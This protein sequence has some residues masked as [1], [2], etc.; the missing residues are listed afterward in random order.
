LLVLTLILVIFLSPSNS[1]AIS[2]SSLDYLEDNSEFN[3][4]ALAYNDP[5]NVT[6]LQLFFD[7]IFENQLADYNIPGV[8]L[9]VVNATDILYL[10]GYGYANIE[11]SRLV[12]PNTTMFRAASISK[13]FVWTAV[14]QLVEQEIL[15]LD[16]DINQY[17]TSF[18]IP[19][20]FDTPITLSHL[21]SHSAGFEVPTYKSFEV[22]EVDP[23]FFEEFMSKYVPKVVFHPGEISSYSNYGAALAAYIVGQVTNKSFEEYVEE[24]IFTPL[25]MTHSTF[26]QPIPSEFEDDLVTCYSFCGDG[27]FQAEPFR[28]VPMYPSGALS[29]SAL[30]AAYFMM[31]HLNNGSIGTNQILEEET[32]QKMHLQHFTNYPSFDGFAHGFMEMTINNQCFIWHGGDF[33]NHAQSALLLL[34]DHNIGFFFNYNSALNLRMNVIN[35]FMNHF[36]PTSQPTALTPPEDF[37]ARGKKY[38]GNYYTSQGPFSSADKIKNIID[39]YQIKLSDEGYLLFRNYK[40]V[41]IDTHLFREQNGTIRMAF[42]A[43]DQ[44]K[45]LYMFLSDVPIVTFIKQ[46]GA[47]RTATSWGIVFTVIVLLLYTLIYPLIGWIRRKRRKQKKP[48]RTRNERFTRKFLITTSSGYVLHLVIFGGL[49]ATLLESDAALPLLKVLQVVPFLLLIPLG[50]LIVYTILLWKEKQGDLMLR[51]NSTIVI[52]TIG[53]FLWWMNIWN[54]LGFSFI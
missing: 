21:M 46:L 15:E 20:K 32:A 22:N 13:L 45:I 18:K 50:F 37:K 11:E 26:R 1:N 31:A 8:T 17:L 29:I 41:E 12:S 40:F 44:G 54:W 49:L 47:E 4:I 9:S 2:Y 43:N 24:N 3:P 28:F 23:L 51:I 52:I 5:N 16:K 35:E 34:L 48:Q 6:E 33:T 19:N 36:Y 38:V 30:D 39:Y 42:R 14:M 25:G 27:I 7:E 10:K 53:L